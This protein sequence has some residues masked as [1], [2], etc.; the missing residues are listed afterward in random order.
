M[1]QAILYCMAFLYVLTGSYHFWRPETY[2]KIMPQWVLW[3]AV[4]N[5]LTGVSEIVLGLLLLPISTRNVAAWGLI[6]L[7]ILVFP[8]NIQ[9]A[10][11][12]YEAND[13]YLWL[14]ILR[15]PLQLLLIWWA[16]SYTKLY[17][18]PT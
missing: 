13:P 7:L 16:Y 4:V 2:Y 6:V 17:T 5:I 3:P 15:L 1:K 9:M 14:A 12:Y 11:N 8:A 10:V 18:F